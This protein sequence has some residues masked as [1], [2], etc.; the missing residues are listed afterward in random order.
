MLDQLQKKDATLSHEV[1]DRT[2]ELQKQN[3]FID[4]L[5]RSSTIMAI[6]ATD[7]DF[8]V[9]YFNPRAEELFGHSA[10]Q[11]LGKRVSQFH[12]LVN[13]KTKDMGRVLEKVKHS[14][15]HTFTMEL[16]K[17]ASV[18][19]IEATL[20]AIRDQNEVMTGLM[21]MARDI[22]YARK[23][24]AHLQNVLAEIKTILDNT[25]AGVILVQDDHIVRV[26]STVDKML[27]YT[28]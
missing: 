21:L 20:S 7:L 12:P 1:V 4:N 27:V 11:V 9:T 28:G 26:N 6:A 24:E 14:G 2:D 8:K 16:K 25:F 18:C 3:I 17:D 5:L 15:T 13:G 10:E 19:I 23:Q 22:S